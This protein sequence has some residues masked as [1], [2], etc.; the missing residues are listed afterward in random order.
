VLKPIARQSPSD[1]A[2]AFRLAL[3]GWF[4][5]HGKDY[6]WRR[7]IDPYAVLVSEV[8]LQQTQIATVLDRGYYARWMER[9]PDVRTLAGASEPEVLRTWEGLGYYRRAR[10]LHQLA[11]TILT[12]HDGVFPRDTASILAL[13]GVGR[14]TAGAV[15]SFAFDDAEPIVDGNVARVLSRICNDP[16]PVDTTEG[17]AKLWE[18]ALHLVQAAQSPRTLNSA[19]MELGQRVCRTGA[20]ACNEC[21]VQKCCAA[22]EPASLPVKTRRASITEVTERV[23]FHR[24]EEGI[25]LQQETGKRRTGLWKLPALP[26]MPKFPPVLHKAHY[27]ITRYRVTL[28]VHEAPNA[29]ALRPI[30]AEGALRKVP[31]TELPH[32][33]MPS[34][35][36]KALDAVL[37]Q[38]DFRLRHD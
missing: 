31:S 13:P 11:K 6:P 1:D 36:R 30:M 37:S 29:N 5:K 24:T 23:F 19:L 34:P 8:M 7:T 32:L 4:E 25:L 14:Y 21:P 35:Y 12:K 3:R 9:F 15:A 20:P 38:A 18:H 27:S 2:A 16:T 33:P 17:Q 26:V 28:W 10:F 22:V